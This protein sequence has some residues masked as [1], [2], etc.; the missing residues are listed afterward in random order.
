MFDSDLNVF[1]AGGSGGFYFLHCLLLNKQHFCHFPRQID[2]TLH[3]V[4]RLE[5]TDYDNIKTNTQWPSYEEYLILGNAGN[6]ELISAE[7]QWA[8]N[9][10][11]VPG[12]F[13]KQFD[14][15]HSKNWNI[16]P[17]AWKSTEIWPRNQDTLVRSCTDR[18]YKIFY[19]CAG[20]IDDVEEWLKWPGKKI[21]LYTDIR[22]QLRLA[23]SKKAWYYYKAK[24]NQDKIN[25]IKKEI[26]QSK[27]YK[28]CDVGLTAFEALQHADESVK[29]QD[30]IKLM[31]SDAANKQQQ[32]FTHQ[33][34]NYHSHDLRRRSQLG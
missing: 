34:L 9:Y 26:R 27:V 29:L 10:E 7:Q 12:W 20:V 19:T 28:Q 3:P 21:V 33:W 4:L 25:I 13:D 2:I 14:V 30:F 32:Q 16:N 31:S 22:T 6:P 5:K 15:I 18:K 11:M 8:F 23:M 24:N 17:Q 1:Y